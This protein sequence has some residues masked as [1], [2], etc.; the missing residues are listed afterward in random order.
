[1]Q[2]LK[3]FRTLPKLDGMALAHSR[4]RLYVEI[5]L[6]AQFATPL[7][8]HAAD[9]TARLEPVLPKPYAER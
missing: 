5:Y 2:L 4:N 8:L 6:L 1:M 3:I 9:R 7:A